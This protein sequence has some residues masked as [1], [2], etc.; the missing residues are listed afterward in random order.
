[1]VFPSST[2]IDY[3]SMGLTQVDGCQRIVPEDIIENWEE[4]QRE[5]HR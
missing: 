5:E 3:E 1:M 2:E 4:I